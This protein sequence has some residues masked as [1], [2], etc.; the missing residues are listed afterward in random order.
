M[1]AQ[2]SLTVHEAKRIIGKGIAMRPEV[3]N[4]LKSGKIFLK[5]GTTVSAVCEE[6]IG[7]PLLIAGR[8][9]P[10]GTIMAHNFSG[11][12]HSALIVKGELRAVDDILEESLSTLTAADVAIIGANAVDVY[13]N[14]ALMYGVALGGKPAK[15]I[16]GL[17][18]EISNIIVAVGLEKLVPGSINDIILKTGRKDVKLSMGMAVGLTPMVGQIMTEKEAVALLGSV[19]S[20]VIGKGG[21]AWAEGGTTLQ[22]E[23]EKREVEKV[24][25]I[26]HS[27]KGAQVSGIS[28]SLPGC[29]APHEKCKVHRGCIY[30]KAKSG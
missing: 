4:A 8:I 3:Q 2:V 13:G 24:F 12:F 30:K 19:S 16:S 10:K 20:T 18:S 27:S 23:G 15:I 9:S 22:I 6:L 25:Q 17:M 29:V 14:A 28:E 1:K 26:I 21:I 7:K 5:G 11:Q